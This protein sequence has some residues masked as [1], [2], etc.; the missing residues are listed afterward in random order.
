V[1][2]EGTTVYD[3]WFETSPMPSSRVTEDAF[4][5]LQERRED[6]P[7]VIVLGDAVKE[8]MFGR[9]VVEIGFTV[10]VTLDV[11]L[12]LGFVAVK[13]YVV[14]CEGVTVMEV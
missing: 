7:A 11:A 6:A 9:P 2:A 13:V 3:V 4:V 14:D 10:T 1:V 5:T 8:A 12:P